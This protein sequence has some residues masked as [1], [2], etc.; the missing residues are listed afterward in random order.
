MNQH[1]EMTSCDYKGIKIINVYR[2]PAANWSFFKK[3]L[4]DHSDWFVGSNIILCG[5][6]NDTDLAKD[7]SLFKNFLK[8]EFLLDMISPCEATTN[9]GT[10]IDAVFAKLNDYNYEVFI[11]ESYFSHHK[12]IITKLIKK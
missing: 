2:N 4:Q 8:S 6:F 3:F 1:I 7:N 11:Y 10:T 12:P 5:D 9:A